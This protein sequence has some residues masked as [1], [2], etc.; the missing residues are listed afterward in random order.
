MIKLTKKEEE[1]RKRICLAL[2]VSD[3]KEA[4]TLVDEL[5]DYVGIFKIGKQLHIAAGNQSINIVQAI[6]DKGG[7]IFLDLK[8]HDTPNTVFQASKECSVSGVCIFNVHIA[9]GEK[10]CKQA[11][12]GA[13]QG[14]LF[15]NIKTP[16]VI[17]VT[18]LTSLNDEDLKD[19]HLGIKY[20][21][22]VERRTELAKKWGLDGIVC[23]ANKAGEL[24]KKFGSDFLYITPGIQWGGKMGKG[25]KQLYTADLA[26]KDCKN[27]ILVIGSAITNSEDKKAIA[28]EILQAM[29][30]EL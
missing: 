7:E 19:Q 16:K 13:K 14:A 27:S 2:D 1:A 21:D 20:D 28:Y 3:V 29:A 23:P 18:V 9:G 26:V 15:Y 25:Q 22:L 11:I 6:S 8:L 17:G 10:M 24:E 30:K 5:S 4:L 12:E